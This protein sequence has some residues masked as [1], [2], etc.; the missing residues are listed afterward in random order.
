MHPLLWFSVSFAASGEIDPV[1][2]R[3]V[4]E[5]PIAVS[6]SSGK[7]TRVHFPEQNQTSSRNHFPMAEFY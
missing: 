4:V 7:A 6:G 1:V 3:R 2:V 5:I